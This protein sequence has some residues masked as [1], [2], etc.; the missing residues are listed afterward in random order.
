MMLFFVPYELRDRGYW[1]RMMRERKLGNP[2][3]CNKV[4]KEG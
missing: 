2:D 3:F 1:V 4:V